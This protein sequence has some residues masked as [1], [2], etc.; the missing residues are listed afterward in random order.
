MSV[1]E[2]KMLAHQLYGF[3]NLILYG[4]ETYVYII[5]VIN[6]RESKI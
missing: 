3:Y 1:T 4:S 2:F 5:I 6:F